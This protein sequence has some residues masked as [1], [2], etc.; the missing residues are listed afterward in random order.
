MGCDFEP[1]PTSDALVPQPRLARVVAI[2][3]RAL[4]LPIVVNLPHAGAGV[5]Q[6]GSHIA[7]TAPNRIGGFRTAH[8]QPRKRGTFLL[9][10]MNHPRTEIGETERP[11]NLVEP[12]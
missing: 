7:F 9:G 10:V 11:R 1:R 4:I 6:K 5:G 8:P 3:T 12:N 2:T